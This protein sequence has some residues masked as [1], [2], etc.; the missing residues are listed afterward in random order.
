MS[1]KKKKLRVQIMESSFLHNIIENHHEREWWN[2]ENEEI[3][4]EWMRNKII[5]YA[6][7]TRKK[8]R[9]SVF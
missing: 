2:V 7:I 9:K 3:M 8:T 1:S 5:K 4:T 6:T